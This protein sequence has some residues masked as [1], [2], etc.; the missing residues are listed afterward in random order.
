MNTKLSEIAEL[1]NGYAFRGRIAHQKNGDTSVI[2]ASDLVKQSVVD[3]TTLTCVELGSRGDRFHLKA[4]DVVFVARGLHQT[5]YKPIADPF[6]LFPMPIVTPAGLIT[7]R[8]KQSIALPEYIVWVL[9]SPS[10]QREIEKY[11][12]GSNIRF[13]SEANLGNIAIPL[14]PMPVQYEIVEMLTLHE[15]RQKIR[16]TLANADNQIIDT[17]VWSL[18]TGQNL[19]GGV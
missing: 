8:V 14:P 10:V 2:N 15:R 7:I 17:V 12:E 11:K 1:N 13:I 4:H 9:N 5:A 3:L 6:Y 16:E 19:N 18:A